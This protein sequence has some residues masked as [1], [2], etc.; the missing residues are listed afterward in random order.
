MDWRDALPRLERTRPGSSLVPVL[1]SLAA[2]SRVLLVQPDVGDGGRWQAP[3][4]SLVVQR[5]GEWADALEADA[6][7]RV[8]DGTAAGPAT[9]RTSIRLTLYRKAG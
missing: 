2:G 4:T 6:R 9:T 3:W 7:F 1:D 5:T 8:V